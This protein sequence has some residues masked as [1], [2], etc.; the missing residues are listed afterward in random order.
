[1]AAILKKKKAKEMLLYSVHSLAKAKEN[2]NKQEKQS[3]MEKEKEM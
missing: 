3:K 2:K 1:M